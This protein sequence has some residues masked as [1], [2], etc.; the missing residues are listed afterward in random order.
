MKSV[1]NLIKNQVNYH[2]QKSKQE[3]EPV[4]KVNEGKVNLSPG[5]VNRIPITSRHESYCSNLQNLLRRDP[6]FSKYDVTLFL[7]QRIDLYNKW[8]LRCG[9]HEDGKLVTASS[10][11]IDT[12]QIGKYEVSAQ[13][14]GFFL[15]LQKSIEAKLTGE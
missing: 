15:R 1:I 2:R 13:V 3:P 14:H 11:I 10:V 8:E 5:A 7:V 9:I 4:S 12:L 6:F